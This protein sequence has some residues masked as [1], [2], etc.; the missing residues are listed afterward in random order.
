MEMDPLEP[1]IR[2]APEPSG[3]AGER[4]STVLTWSYLGA[5]YKSD[6]HGGFAW[7]R[8]ISGREGGGCFP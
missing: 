2:A 1:R 5:Y 7:A 8:F 3:D 6:R 4:F